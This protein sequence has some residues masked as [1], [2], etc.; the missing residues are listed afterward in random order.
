MRSFPTITRFLNLFKR[1]MLSKNWEDAK[2]KTYHTKNHKLT[3]WTCMQNKTII[4]IFLTW[5]FN[6]TIS[7][8]YDLRCTYTFITYL[9]CIWQRELITTNM[10][11]FIFSHSLIFKCF[12]LKEAKKSKLLQVNQSKAFSYISR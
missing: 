5:F 3:K 1:K 7:Y 12:H 2:P 10:E 8:T 11:Y 6:L 9:M 4:I